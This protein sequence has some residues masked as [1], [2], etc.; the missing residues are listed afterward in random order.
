MPIVTQLITREARS[1]WLLNSH[2]IQNCSLFPVYFQTLLLLPCSYFCVRFWGTGKVPLPSRKPR[3]FWWLH[4]DL[5]SG[6][7]LLVL[8]W[9]SVALGYHLVITLVTAWP[10]KQSGSAGLDSRKILAFIPDLGALWKSDCVLFVVD[11]PT[12]HL[13]RFHDVLLL[14]PFNR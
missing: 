6:K 11:L 13:A 3:F 12:Q 9:G 4:E 10:I 8:F 1:V 7:P 14:F 5:P 2:L